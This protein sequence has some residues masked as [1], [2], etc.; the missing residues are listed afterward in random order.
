[1]NF[2]E[3][4]LISLLKAYLNTNYFS[5][6][7]IVE[8]LGYGVMSDHNEEA[9]KRVGEFLEP[10]RETWLDDIQERDLTDADLETVA[11]VCAM[12]IEKIQSDCYKE[13]G[14]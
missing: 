7:D 1:M 12:N 4:T 9:I 8:L 10:M 11:E 3:E 5:I 14:E 6:E 13:W 2:R